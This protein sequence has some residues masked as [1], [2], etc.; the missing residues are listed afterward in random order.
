MSSIKNKG[1]NE[2]IYDESNIVGKSGKSEEE[3][4]EQISEKIKKEIRKHTDAT[5]EEENKDSK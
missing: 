2:F 1:E 3:E 5:I 4:D